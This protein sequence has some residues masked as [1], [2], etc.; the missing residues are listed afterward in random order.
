MITTPIQTPERTRLAIY[1]QALLES[2][3]ERQVMHL[4]EETSELMVEI[5]HL[6]RGRTSNPKDVALEIADVM[7]MLDLFRHLLGIRSE[8]VRAAIDAKLEK[9]RTQLKSPPEI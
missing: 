4:S 8:D 1:N 3:I 9:F 5:S 6:I 7:V 2:S